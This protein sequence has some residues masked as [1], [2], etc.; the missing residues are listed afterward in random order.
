[1]TIEEDLRITKMNKVYER[2]AELMYETKKGVFSQMKFPE[3][4][5]LDTWLEQKPLT[6][7]EIK[8]ARA[9]AFDRKATQYASGVRQPK[10]EK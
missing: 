3:G 7:E 6:P 2:M 9:R 10:P 8:K 1:M 4:E 5:D